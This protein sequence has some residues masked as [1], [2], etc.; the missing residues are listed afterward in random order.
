MKSYPRIGAL[1]VLAVLASFSFRAEAVSFD[2]PDKTFYDVPNKYPILEPGRFDVYQFV[3][4]DVND[5]VVPTLGKRDLTPAVAYFPPSGVLQGLDN[6]NN[7]PDPGPNTYFNH[8]YDG[9]VDRTPHPTQAISGNFDANPLKD[10]VVLNWE[11]FIVCYNYNGKCESWSNP[12]PITVPASGEDKDIKI[13]PWVADVADF[14]GDGKDDLVISGLSFAPFKGW[15]TVFKSKGTGG[16]DPFDVYYGPKEVVDGFPLALVAADTDGDGKIDVT[17]ANTRLPKGC[18]TNGAFLTYFKNTG[19][20]FADSPVSRTYNIN[21]CFYASD[22][23]ADD[24]D[25][26]GKSDLVM[27]CYFALTPKAAAALDPDLD[28]IPEVNAATAPSC[29]YD[30]MP[31]PVYI[32]KG[33]GSG[34]VFNDQQKLD[35]L[36]YPFA[37]TCSDY[38]KDGDLDCAVTEHQGRNI[39][40]YTGTG[41]FQVETSPNRISTDSFFPLHIQSW[42]MNGDTWTDIVVVA[43]D[44]Q[45]NL[46]RG[47]VNTDVSHV[48]DNVLASS[49]LVDR[50]S[51]GNASVLYTEKYDYANLY[52]ADAFQPNLAE[53][54]I[55]WNGDNYVLN[56]SANLIDSKYRPTLLQNQ[57]AG[58]AV[59]LAPYQ[60]RV[61][62]ISRLPTDGVLVL[63]NNQSE[64]TIDRPDC[65]KREGTFRCLASE[66]HKITACDATV[67]DPAATITAAAPVAGTDNR[68]WKGSYKLPATNKA[69]KIKVTGTDD[70]PKTVT[71]ELNADLSKC[72]EAACPAKTLTLETWAWVPFNLCVEDG[73]GAGAGG[74]PIVWSVNP[75]SATINFGEDSG[76]GSIT[77]S[78]ECLQGSLNSKDKPNYTEKVV[79]DGTYKLQGTN[80][81]CPF[82]VV[83][84]PIELRGNRFCA[85]GPVGSFSLGDAAGLFGTLLS[86]IAGL[87]AWRLKKK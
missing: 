20:S 77:T 33:D 52:T 81:S 25:E 32:L 18:D 26:D 10:I 21:E 82:Q 46:R 54:N 41:A 29:S 42:D 27:T 35:G 62:V 59:E 68:E 7:W 58:D 45:L 44:L 60:E 40:I 65:D 50:V 49:V 71:G 57:F 79:V 16:N 8:N 61:S 87:G 2:P 85:L 72:A 17:T 19:A 69:Y 84:N 38:D 31:G 56:Y 83:G 22:L 66:G 78:G 47:T 53:Q 6:K 70:T 64:V 28:L 51:L 9:N 1:A 39:A 15:V 48:S 63:V 74:K 80:V 5:V 4:T 36:N 30:W 23:I 37:T 43:N 34:T 73:F 55:T 13:L 3:G 12:I 75:G 76:S 14:S 11:H 86:A 67:D 24:P